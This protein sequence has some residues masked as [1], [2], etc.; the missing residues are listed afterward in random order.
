M[1]KILSAVLGGAAALFITLSAAALPMPEIASESAIV[2]DAATGQVLYEKDGYSKQYPA[3]ITKIM[4]GLLVLEKGNLSDNATITNTAV[5]IEKNASNIALIPG[6]EISVEALMYGLA[7]ES[8]NDAAN[9]LGEYIA[10]SQQAFARLMTERAK[11]LGAQNTN[12]V[13][14]SGLHD[15]NHYTTAYDMAMIARECIKHP[16]FNTIFS[17]EKYKI[18]ATNKQV[19][20]TLNCANWFVNGAYE[21]DGLVM[22][23]IGWTEEATHTMVTVVERNDMTLI[24]VVMRSSAK[25]QKWE[26]TEK[27]FDRAFETFIPVSLSGEKIALSGDEIIPCNEKGT[28]YVTRESITA[29]GATVLVTNEADIDNIKVTYSSPS[30]SDDMQTAYFTATISLDGKDITSVKAEAPIQERKLSYETPTAEVN[31][32]SDMF[33]SVIFGVLTFIAVMIVDILINKRI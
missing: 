14:A 11:E 3:S 9:A 32:I 6:E 20:R 23:K 29:E 22:T 10:G 12:F 25:K 1:R 18:P 13:N 17:T 16:E 30:V 28:L 5:Q 21:I 2:M 19:E 27:L 26:D 7:I 33:V 15:S 4:T 8:A 31:K 24:C